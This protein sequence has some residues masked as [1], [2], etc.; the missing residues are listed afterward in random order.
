MHDAR[1]MAGQG[2]DRMSASCFQIADTPL[3][4]GAKG[5]GT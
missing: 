3:F 5:I 1:I 2:H 4:D